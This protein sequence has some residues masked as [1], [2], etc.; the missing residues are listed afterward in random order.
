M[1]AGGVGVFFVLK[2]IVFITLVKGFYTQNNT[3]GHSYYDQ[4]HHDYSETTQLISFRTLHNFNGYF[5]LESFESLGGKARSGIGPRPHTSRKFVSAIQSA[6]KSGVLNQLIIAMLARC[7]DINP[8]PGPYQSVQKRKY[9]HKYQCYKCGCGIRARRIHCDNQCDR[10]AHAG[11]IEG[12][13]NAIFDIISAN[14][15]QIKHN[16]DICIHTREINANTVIMN[17]VSSSNNSASD[18]SPNEIMGMVRPRVLDGT[19]SGAQNCDTTDGG[20]RN[21]KDA[22]N[23]DCQFCLNEIKKNNKSVLCLNSHKYHPRCYKKASVG[24]RL[25]KQ[26]LFNELP[27]GNIDISIEIYDNVNNNSVVMPSKVPTNIF[28]CF[29][30]KGLHFIHMN[31]RSV[32]NKLTEIRIITRE[33]N[34]AVLSIT[35][36]W[37]EESHTMESI[38]IEGY[39]IVR[40]D[41]K[42]HAG[43]VLMY[44]RSDL[45]YNHRQD[46][47]NDN[48]EDLW[49]ELLL[50]DTKKNIYW[51][52]LQG[53]QKQ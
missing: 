6:S 37:L 41:R 46:L 30:N 28:D 7:G 19:D 10:V 1:A 45:A 11:C 38:S 21:L 12:L 44:V 2:T 23:R 47:Q 42:T 4:N 17:D 20:G 53:S 9:I 31:A 14:G 51:N 27:F 43:G 52:M 24:D 8:N 3:T 32:F 15:E 13:T 25:C 16:C 39:N 33:T 35:E 48:L 26:C 22:S 5:L 36:S 49:I 18:T 40:R 50:Q 29:K 34:P